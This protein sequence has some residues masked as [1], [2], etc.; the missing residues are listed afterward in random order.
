M[1]RLSVECTLPIL[2]AEL[3]FTSNDSK[4]IAN[5]TAASLHEQI[6]IWLKNVPSDHHKD[7]TTRLAS[8]ANYTDKDGNAKYTRL[9]GDLRLK[10]GADY[11]LAIAAAERLH[12]T[13]TEWVMGG[14]NGFGSN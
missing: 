12:E 4:D 13:V 2:T 1:N 8:G 5:A 11:P 10:P 3:E 14:A 7:R 9:D 6:V